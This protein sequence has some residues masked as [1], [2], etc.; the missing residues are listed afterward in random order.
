MLLTSSPSSYAT[1]I[2]VSQPSALGILHL[3]TIEVVLV[4]ENGRGGGGAAVRRPSSGGKRWSD[5]VT[6]PSTVAKS[7]LA[8]VRKS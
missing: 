8:L 3:P 2:R 4:A 6:S 1:H 5:A 7:E